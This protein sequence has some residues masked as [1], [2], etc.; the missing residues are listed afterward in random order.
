MIYANSR[1][2]TATLRTVDA[3]ETTRREM[4]VPLPASRRLAYTLYRIHAG[5]RIDL[6]AADSFGDPSLW[7]MIANANPEILDWM[8][9]P[10]GT[11]IRIPNG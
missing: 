10:V 3:G 2:T 9:L 5:D 6:L 4:R 1:Y 7:W 8:N 11:V